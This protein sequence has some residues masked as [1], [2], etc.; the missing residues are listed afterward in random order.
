MKVFILFMLILQASAFVIKPG[1]SRNLQLKGIEFDDEPF[2]NPESSDNNNNNNNNNN[3]EESEEPQIGIR[4]IF[5]TGDPRMN[6]FVRSAQNDN[7]KKNKQSENFVVIDDS[8]ITFKDVGGYDNVKKEMMQC[9]DIL[10]NYTKY[11]EYNVRTP[12]GMILEGPPGNGKTLL[13]KGFSGETKSSFIPVSGS[14]FQEKYVGVGASRVRELFELASKNTPCIIFIDEVD[15]IGRT[16]SNDLDSSNAERDN[17]LNE[18]LVKLDGFKK[19]NGIF[20]ICATNR[21]DLLDKALLRPGRID[22]KIYIGNPDSKTRQRILDIHLSGKPIEKN[23]KLEDL[24]EITNGLS[25]ADIENL[26]NEAMLTAL[27]ENR[28]LITKQDLE[29]VMGRSLAGFQA[30]ENMFSEDM[31]KRI[32]MHEL[33]HAITGLILKDHS[34]MSRVNLNLWSPSSPGYTIFETEE[35]DANIFTGEKLFAHL[36]V[37]LGGRVAEETFFNKSVTTGASKDFSE[38]YKLAEQMIVTYGMGSKN[39]F[40]YA[41]DKSKEMIDNEVSNLLEKAL[42]KSRNIITNSKELMEELCPILIEDQALSRDTIEMK[43]Y[44]K[45]PSL[46]KLD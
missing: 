23:I 10:T 13:A 18:L 27:R 15:A 38:A 34:K 12:K 31:I 42:E 6:G 5:P 43:M 37:L 4:I 36:V 19:S 32:A 39:I 21:I 44:R 26:L 30:N 22:K 40:P 46:F 20:L 17:T 14:E 28:E 24:I 29:Y 2:P 8:D 16:R 25:G 1:F 3:E 9:A 7:D 35:I 11:S 45:Y 33:G 41:S